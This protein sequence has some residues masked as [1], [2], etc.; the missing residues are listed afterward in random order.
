MKRLLIVVLCVLVVPAMATHIV[1]GEFEIVHLNGNSYRINLIL[2]FDQLNGAPGARDPSFT[3]AIYRKRDNQLM[4]TVFF[5]GYSETNVDYTQPECSNGEIVTRKLVYSR[6]V[7]LSDARYNDPQ[8]YYIIWE[9]CCRNYTITNIY[10]E[11]P[12]FSNR[13]AGQ[14]FYLEFPPV[15]K[16]GEPFINSSPRLFPPLNDYACPRK[17]YYVDF[18]GIDDDGDSL[19]YSLVTP[20]T[21]HS[22]VAIPPLLPRPYPTVQWRPPFSL[23]NILGGAPDLRISPDGF[24][25]ATPTQ[26]G[27]YVFAVKCDEFRNGEKIGEVRRDFQMLVVDVCPRAEAPQILG[28]KLADAS[29]SFD[30][31][32]QVTFSNTVTD[33]QRCIEVQVSDPDASKQDDNFSENVQIRAVPIGFRKDVKGILPNVT[34]ATLVNG[35]VKT[36]KLCFVECPY[37]EGPFQVGIVAYDDACSLPLS[38]T[39]V[40]TVNIVPPPNANAYFTTPNVVEVLNEGDKKTW[41]IAGLD[42]DGDQLIVGVVASGFKMETVGM[43]IEQIK[44]ENGEYEAFLEWDTRCDVYDFTKKTQFDVM[45]ILEDVDECNFT[46]PDVMTL[47]LTV[48]LP[49]NLDPIIDSDLTPDLQERTVSGLKRKVNETLA[50]NVT[51][52]DGD[53]DL[54]VLSATGVGFNISDYNITF[55]TV[56]G[57]GLVTSPFLWNIFCDDVNLAVKDEFTFRFVVVDNANKCRFYKADTLD[58]TVK[59]Y[60]PDNSGPTLLIANLNQ[61]M[62]LV[63]NSMVVT[64]GQ[65]I[66]LGLTGTDSDN[67]PTPDFLR[68]DLINVEGEPADGYLF[69][70]AEGRKTVQTTFTWNPQCSIFANGVYEND[71]TFTFR[72]I[73]D[74]CFNSKGDTLAID[75]TIK[76]VERSDAEFLPPNIIT[77]NGD[78]LNEYFA[79]VKQDENSG[80][81][82]NILPKDNCTGRF[83]GITIFNRWGKQVYESIDREFKWYA[84]GQ[85][86]GEYFYLLKYSDKEYKGIITVSFAESQSI[87]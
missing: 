50:F 56:S 59:L 84:D 52:K 78:Q 14:T 61:E 39:L 22:L 18:A 43:K 79:M 60:P 3:T 82:V 45:I 21:T 23:S 63:D 48:K 9:R 25:T 67:L 8:G 46:H 28:K 74:R 66:T 1:G 41:P 75:I 81:L 35:S 6:V 83:E 36:F 32:M 70:S 29:F 72:V 57:N 71:Y 38:D 53:N 20:L 87:R 65:Q 26:Q 30:E 13:A 12:A 54:L 64:L 4:E 2:Y 16:N 27:L 73:D 40:V 58:V 7:T 31:N 34:S 69:E 86:S 77:P 11:D 37:V 85:S 19:A 49:G 62:Q 76:D 17:P 55:P 51:G 33:E 47:R 42:P 24:L 15:V 68:L 10:S 5:Q 44:N 80:L